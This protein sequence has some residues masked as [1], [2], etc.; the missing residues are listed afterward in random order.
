MIRHGC[1]HGVDH[2][3]SRNHSEL[4]LSF[5]AGN[6]TT[7]VAL[8]L[9]YCHRIHHH[10]L[11]ISTTWGI[12]SKI[13]FDIQPSGPSCR[14]TRQP[15]ERRVNK[16]RKMSR[17]TQATRIKPASIRNTRRRRA[18]E[19]RSLERESFRKRALSFIA[20]YRTSKEASNLGPVMSSA[21]S[22]WIN[23]STAPTGRTKSPRSNPP[24]LSPGGT[25]ACSATN[26]RRAAL[27][28]S[29]G[30]SSYL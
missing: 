9:H 26:L 22:Q 13:Y 11:Q 5:I 3:S 25:D 12:R 10:Q 30:M 19:K 20:V 7:C 6:T 21:W 4:P 28:N 29:G 17:T 2:G 18:S 8:P 23:F 14:S 15:T 16:Y 24:P 27:L 1:H